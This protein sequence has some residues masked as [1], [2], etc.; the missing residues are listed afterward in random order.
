[1]SQCYE[2]GVLSMQVYCRWYR[3]FVLQ[4]MNDITKSCALSLPYGFVPT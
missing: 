4:M 1:M 3:A 2:R